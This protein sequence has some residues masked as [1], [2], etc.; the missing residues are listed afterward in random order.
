M[1]TIASRL[2]QD[3]SAEAFTDSIYSEF[4]KNFSSTRLLRHHYV[5]EDY[6]WLNFI[7]TYGQSNKKPRVNALE[8][9]IH[10]GRKVQFLR[11]EQE[12]NRQE[13]KS[14]AS[15]PI[16]GEKFRAHYTVPIRLLL[17]HGAFITRASFV[18]ARK[19]TSGY[20][21]TVPTVYVRTYSIIAEVRMIRYDAEFAEKRVFILRLEPVS[22]LH[23][24]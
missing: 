11:G 5:V 21:R 8:A 13:L 12:Y 16:S 24:T 22:E 23:S 2:F 17:Q 6:I 18:M 7:R 3:F 9:E 19:T 1:F 10:C 14:G 4:H 15:L 20:L